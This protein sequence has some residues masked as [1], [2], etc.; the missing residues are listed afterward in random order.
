MV[1]LLVTPPSEALTCANAQTAAGQQTG[2]FSAGV[3]SRVNS[4]FQTELRTCNY[5]Y[6]LPRVTLTSIKGEAKF[7]ADLYTKASACCSGNNSCAASLTDPQTNASRTALASLPAEATGVRDAGEKTAQ[8]L[9]LEL[10]IL[11]SVAAA[12]IVRSKACAERARELHK[13]MV[14]D[15][16]CQNDPT[17]K[18]SLTQ[19]QQTANRC[20]Q[21]LPTGVVALMNGIKSNL[22]LAQA[23]VEAT[24][25]EDPEVED[26]AADKPSTRQA[27]LSSAL[28]TGLSTFAQMMSAPNEDN[29]YDDSDPPMDCASNPAIAGCSEPE[30]DSWNTGSN[31]SGVSGDRSGASGFNPTDMDLSN[32]DTGEQSLNPAAAARGGASNAGIPNGGGGFGG[33]GGGAPAALGPA[34]APSGP[35]AGP[36]SAIARDMM[37]G[38]RGGGG[39]SQSPGMNGAVNTEGGG[40][41]GYGRG[42]EAGSKMDLS[43]FLPG[44]AKDPA[45]AMAGLAKPTLS[46]QVNN[47]GVNIW[48]RISDHIRTRCSQGLLRDCVP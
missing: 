30:S 33:G 35:G 24:T 38:E 8:T 12:C 15:P 37:K 23:S 18:G 6:T 13:I 25:A 41:S 43:Q 31:F 34:S 5:T 45:R 28:M 17:C 32:A 7:A 44:G 11:Q 4:V 21:L 47:A 3:M 16:L 1:L 20:T 39:Y 26:Q 46:R 2:P 9:T 48:N 27:M 29:G 36:G 14:A 42:A 19:V 22:D 40:F 10:E